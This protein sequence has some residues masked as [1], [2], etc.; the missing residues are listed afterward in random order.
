[1]SAALTDGTFRHI[2]FQSP[3]ANDR[4]ILSGRY[5]YAG[6]YGCVCSVG[7]FE[8]PMLIWKTSVGEFALLLEG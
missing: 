7:E 4:T 1:M 2:S 8:G 6:L 5:E 3:N